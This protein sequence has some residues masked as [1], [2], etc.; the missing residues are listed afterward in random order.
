MKLAAESEQTL[1]VMAGMVRERDDAVKI[2]EK[3]VRDGAAENALQ[4]LKQFWTDFTAQSLWVD[5]PE[6]DIDRLVNIWIKYQH[7]NSMLENLNTRRLGFGIWCPAY[8]YGAGRMS[9]IR[10]TGNVSCD[11]KLIRDDILDYLHGGPLLLESDLKLKW[12]EPKCTPPPPPYPH[13]GRGLWPYPVC[14]YIKET[15][16]LSFLNTPID[17]HGRIPSAPPAGYG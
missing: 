6:K 10:E 11:L 16:D 4:Q 12:E 14:W 7:R 3:Y 8:S 9:D 5:T 1:V 15:G 13:D 2:R 17:H